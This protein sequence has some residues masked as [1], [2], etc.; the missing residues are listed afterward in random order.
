MLSAQV[1]SLARSPF[2]RVALALIVTFLIYEYFHSPCNEPD[3]TSQ[4]PWSQSTSSLKNSL[5]PCAQVS[6]EKI[7][8]LQ[9]Y[10]RLTVH[11]FADGAAIT[12]SLQL[13]HA[14]DIC[15]LISVPQHQPSERPKDV[16]VPGKGPDNLHVF[17][18]SSKV[19]LS[20]PPPLPLPDQQN[21]DRIVASNSSI[22]YSVETKLYHEGKYEVFVDHEVSIDFLN[23]TSWQ[24]CS[25]C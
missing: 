25:A 6:Q 10:E 21:L 24:I 2:A 14:T 8:R 4:R 11:S 5:G 15:I 19:E 9:D 16:P 17:I 23:N 13:D 18:N 12:D 3:C 22:I 1:Q 7:R 20:F